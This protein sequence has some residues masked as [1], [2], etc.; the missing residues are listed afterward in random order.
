[1]RA[2]VLGALVLAVVPAACGPGPQG[3]YYIPS[4]ADRT[5]TR[6]RG[7]CWGP[8]RVIVLRRRGV[9]ITV[10]VDR[11]PAKRV[12]L[13]TVVSMQPGTSMRFVSGAVRV[14]SPGAGRA[15]YVEPEF[16]E[17]SGSWEVSPSEVV[18]FSSVGPSRRETLSQPDSPGQLRV[19]IPF[20]KTKFSPRSMELQLPDIATATQTMRLPPVRLTRRVVDEPRP[21]S[22]GSRILHG[23]EARYGPGSLTYDVVGLPP[24]AWVRRDGFTVNGIASARFVP[25]TL[26]GADLRGRLYIVFPS[27]VAWRLSGPQIHAKDL[28]TGEEVSIPLDSVHLSV[29]VRLPITAPLEGEHVTWARFE[30]VASERR[31]RTLVIQLPDL[32]IDGRRTR[33]G[34][35]TFR[36]KLTWGLIPFNC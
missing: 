8:L 14:S 26:D 23:D 34:P 3:I 20:S 16:L 30:V 9:G 6:E 5:A 18:D 2:A 29:D 35:I 27:S 33:V 25:E 13:T 15:W 4:S 21:P 32:V 12:T 24:A 22:A 28:E 10:R 19:E 1:M 7:D 17:V 31:H 11:K 36:K